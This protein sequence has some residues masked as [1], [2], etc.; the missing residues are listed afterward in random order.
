MQSRQICLSNLVDGDRQEIASDFTFGEQGTIGFEEIE[1]N[2]V[3]PQNIAQLVYSP[4]NFF[5]TEYLGDPKEL[6]DKFGGLAGK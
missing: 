6:A 2:S 5:W 4:C 1:Y 3:L